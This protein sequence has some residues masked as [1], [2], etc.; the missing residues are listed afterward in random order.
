MMNPNWYWVVWQ[1]PSKVEYIPAADAAD[2]AMKYMT[3]NGA[4]KV[5]VVEAG[6]PLEY[7]LDE[8]H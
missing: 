7:E 4:K 3:R 5:F 8:V 2:A 6:V 1:Q